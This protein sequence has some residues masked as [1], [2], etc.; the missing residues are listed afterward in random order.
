[1]MLGEEALHKMAQ[2]PTSHSVKGALV[3]ETR[4]VGHLER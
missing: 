1:M 2:A 3:G 4:T